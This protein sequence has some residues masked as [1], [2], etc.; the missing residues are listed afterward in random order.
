M[1]LQAV[2]KGHLP[3]VGVA[4]VRYGQGT[5]DRHSASHRGPSRPAYFLAA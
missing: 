5:S 3:C 2:A 4:S 1:G